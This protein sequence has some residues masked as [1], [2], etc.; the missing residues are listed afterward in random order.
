MNPEAHVAGR[1]VSR[2]QQFR[3]DGPRASTI[4]SGRSHRLATANS[5]S[6]ERLVHG[7]VDRLGEQM[8][9]RLFIGAADI[10]ARTP[11][12]RL[13]P[14]QDLDVMSGVVT[15]SARTVALWRGS[16]PTRWDV[17]HGREWRTPS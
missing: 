16:V 10:H 7:V 13:E 8:V 11:A 14:L 3:G 5:R 15:A 1:V 6:G 17:R 12:H 2:F 4:G 9:Q